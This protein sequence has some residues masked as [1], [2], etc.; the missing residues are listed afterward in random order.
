MKSSDIAAFESHLRRLQDQ[1]AKIASA[2]EP[3]QSDVSGELIRLFQEINQICPGL[4]E[5]FRGHGKA[6]AL[7]AQISTAVLKIRA[8]IMT[9]RE[10]QLLAEVED[11]LRTLPPKATIRH[12][13]E[14]NLSWLGRAA[15]V[16]EQ[17]EPL[18]AP[19]FRGYLTQFHNRTAQESTE[20]F[21][22]MMVLLH[23]AH[24]AL[25]LRTIG[26][27]NVAVGQGRVYEYFEQIRRVIELAIEEVFFVDSYLDAEFVS[28]Y[29]PLVQAGT[30]IR[31]LTGP[32]AKKLTTL[33]PAVD[34]FIQQNSHPVEVRSTAGMHDR[35]LFVDRTS[36]YL[37]G[38]SFKDGAKKASAIISQVTDAFKA[39]W[40][41][42]DAL[43][44]SAKIEK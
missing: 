24:N 16:I 15:N 5:P 40:D 31:L 1:D 39:T 22:Q 29:L 9:N 7:R 23:Q 33:V 2:A 43:W 41:T 14:E 10:Q 20:G 3:I 44:A 35:Y 26:P 8:A 12:D 32:D 30:A 13:T 37:S 38:A 4:L 19:L 21:R 18:K 28:R 6:S 42:C 17:W 27:L 11:V 36:C 34:L 25:R